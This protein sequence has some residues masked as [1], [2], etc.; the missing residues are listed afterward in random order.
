MRRP[1]IGRSV[2]N[3]TNALFVVLNLTVVAWIAAEVIMQV[4]QYRM[5]GRAKPTTR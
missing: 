4:R 5:G 2:W 3:M 1:V